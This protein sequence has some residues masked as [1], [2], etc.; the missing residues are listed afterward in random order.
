MTQP[1][2]P[3]FK[4]FGPEGP[5]VWKPGWKNRESTEDG[6][7][8]V[9]P[10]FFFWL[11]KYGDPFDGW[12]IFFLGDFFYGEKEDGGAYAWRIFFFWR[13]SKLHAKMHNGNFE[14]FPQKSWQCNDPEEVGVMKWLH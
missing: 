11:G 9:A 7:R 4:L 3:G 2:G 10:C 8:K 13:G 14:G 5:T 12:W 1:A 6:P